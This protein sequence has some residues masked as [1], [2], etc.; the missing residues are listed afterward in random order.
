[1]RRCPRQTR[2]HRSPLSMRWG[3]SVRSDPLPAQDERNATTGSTRVALPHQDQEFFHGYTAVPC[4][5][6]V[7]KGSPTSCLC[8]PRKPIFI[9][10]RPLADSQLGTNRTVLY[11]TAMGVVK[12]EGVGDGYWGALTDDNCSTKL[13]CDVDHREPLTS[14]H[15]HLD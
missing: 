9:L 1:V 11:N 12:W 15:L 3:P 14:H 2:A 7:R 13:A 10:P 6:R 5:A 4:V 8:L